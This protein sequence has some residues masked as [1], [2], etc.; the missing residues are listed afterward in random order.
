MSIHIDESV[1]SPSKYVGFDT[2]TSQIENR[3]LKRGFQFN[4]MV[5]GRSGLGKTTLVNT[6][7]SS[8]L[9]TTQGRRSAEE[10]IEKTTEIK[11]HS[12]TLVENNVRLNINVI[13]TPGFGDQINNE[14]CWDPLVKYIKEQHSQYL[15]KELTAQREKFIP[16]TRVHCILYFIP[17]NGTKLKPLDA[18]ALK[19]L[20]E[21]AN[22]VPVIAKSDSLTLP[23]RT[24]FKR[25]LQ[26]E[27]IKYKLDI[28]PYDS[29]ELYEDEKQLNEDIKSLIPFAIAGSERE[30]EINGEMVRGRKSKWGAINIEDVSQCEFVFLRDFLTRTHLQDLIETTSLVHYETFRAKQLIALKENASN[31]NRQSVP[32]SQKPQATTN[33][34]PMGV[35]SAYAPTQSMVSA[36]SES[37]VS[38]LANGETRA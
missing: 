4:I 37:T 33:T 28:Y 8:R 16:D 12:H 17:P 24:A 10:P 3:L 31:A 27:F 13:D 38:A 15:R 2:I 9:A 11:T 23:E 29:D 36:V 19:K 32:I 1:V 7:F 30:F 21:I 25:L 5:V 6:L 20:S 26:N 14:R 22:V 34:T 35:P 18:Q